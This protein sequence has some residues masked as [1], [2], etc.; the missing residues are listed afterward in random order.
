MGFFYF[1]AKA[2]FSL[3]L[4]HPPFAL[5]LV[6]SGSFGT[7]LEDAAAVGARNCFLFFNI[8]PNG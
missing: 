6:A 4:F 2:L 8:N 7:P 1:E 5:S 3:S